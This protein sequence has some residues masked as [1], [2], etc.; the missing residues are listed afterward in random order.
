MGRLNNY[1]RFKNLIDPLISQIESTHGVLPLERGEVEL[2]VKSLRPSE[3][4]RLDGFVEGEGGDHVIQDGVPQHV[5]VGMAD[6][7]GVES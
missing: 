1:L 5:E 3:L 4:L 2:Q 7:L 6:L